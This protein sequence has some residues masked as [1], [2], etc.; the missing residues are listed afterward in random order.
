MV[1]LDYVGC[2]LKLLI[3]ICNMDLSSIIICIYVLLFVCIK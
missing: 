3:L 1:D 2:A